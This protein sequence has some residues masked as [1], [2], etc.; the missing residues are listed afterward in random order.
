MTLATAQWRVDRLAL[1]DG[2]SA[3]HLD[4]EAALGLIRALRTPQ[5][6]ASGSITYIGA[7]GETPACVFP[8][9][10]TMHVALIKGGRIDHVEVVL[11]GTFGEARQ[12]EDTI[13][14]SSESK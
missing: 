3:V 12:I 9:G 8:E 5:V 6:F 14:A 2:K 13:P 10:K 4:R 11:N 7:G 1:S